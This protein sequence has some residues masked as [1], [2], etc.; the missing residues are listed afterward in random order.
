MRTT[1][2]LTVD[3]AQ[4]TGAGLHQ[5]VADMLRGDQALTVAKVNAEF[6]LRSSAD[7]EF[8]SY[9]SSTDLNIADG[10]G[11]LWAARFLTLKTSEL[12]ALRQL[13]TAWQAAYSLVSLVFYPR[14][15]RTPIPERISGVEALMVMLRSAE[16]ADAPV[17]FLGAAPEINARA[18]AKILERMPGLKIAGGRDGYVDNWDP[19]LR[20]IDQSE[21]TLLIVALGCPKQEFWIRD[22][23]AGLRHVKVAVGEG[24]SRTSSRVILR[25]RHTGFSGWGSSGSGGCS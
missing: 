20:E 24:G 6:L 25:A 22:H 15:C 8:R 1:R 14:F 21:A 11:V 4:V 7:E 10:I 2:V 17:F 13:H 5:S 3:I 19:V 12:P 18:R 9:L 23:L 16:E